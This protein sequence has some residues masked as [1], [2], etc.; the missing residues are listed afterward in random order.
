MGLSST[1]SGA[2][3]ALAGHASTPA[4]YSQNS[5][6]VKALVEERDALWQEIGR[7]SC[8]DPPDFCRDP[9]YIRLLKERGIELC[10]TGDD[11][12]NP[13]ISE[14]ITRFRH[15]TTQ[16]EF[17]SKIDPPRDGDSEGKRNTP[18]TTPPE[19][20]EIEEIRGEK[21]TEPTVWASDLLSNSR[22]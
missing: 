6:Q 19:Q 18:T 16:I 14:L 12:G 3:M 22:R 11:K 21:Q 13:Q 8:G 10:Q 4:N 1:L 7:L 9:V 2:W 20:E 5:E 15:L 17:F